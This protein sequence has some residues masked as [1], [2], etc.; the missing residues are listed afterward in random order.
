[1]PIG[2]PTRGIRLAPGERTQELAVDVDGGICRDP[3]GVHHRRDD[4]PRRRQ[5]DARGRGGAVPPL[6]TPPFTTRTHR[7]GTTTANCY[8]GVLFYWVLF[9]GMWCQVEC[10]RCH[11]GECDDVQI[12]FSAVAALDLDHLPPLERL[13]DIADLPRTHLAG[14]RDRFIGGPR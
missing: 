6:C 13:D 10:T 8:Y 9:D 3:L 7:G 14:G 1:M 11:V 2:F 12:R 4:E 5:L